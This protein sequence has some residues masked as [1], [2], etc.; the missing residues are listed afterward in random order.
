MELVSQDNRSN[1][2]NGMF[3]PIPPSVEIQKFS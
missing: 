2:V 1:N 3:T